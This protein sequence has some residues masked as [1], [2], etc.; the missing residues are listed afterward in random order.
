V[1]A[2]SQAQRQL[3]ELQAIDT[4]LAQLAHRR[5]RLPELAEL[6]DLDRQLAAM[7][8]ERLRAHSIP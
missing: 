4:A 8:E 2:D 3:L 1:K 6:A 5:A 7:G